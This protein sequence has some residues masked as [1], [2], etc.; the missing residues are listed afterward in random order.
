MLGKGAGM[1]ML[2]FEGMQSIEGG[3]DCSEYIHL[4]RVRS[5]SA[6]VREM[7]LLCME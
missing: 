6:R 5:M 1:R 4:Q 3:I 7:G 2:R